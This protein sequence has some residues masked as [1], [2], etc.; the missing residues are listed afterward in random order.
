MELY[1]AINKINGGARNYLHM[2]QMAEHMSCDV[3]PTKQQCSCGADLSTFSALD[4]VQAQVT[5]H[6][7]CKSKN[8]QCIFVIVFWEHIIAD[9]SSLMCESH[10]L[11]V[12]L[13][14]RCATLTP[15]PTYASACAKPHAFVS[16]SCKKKLGYLQKS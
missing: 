3:T 16:A 7:W 15:L 10:T 13:T 14:F 1:G 2:L 8:T 12:I 9:L 5:G 4:Q 6:C 11:Q